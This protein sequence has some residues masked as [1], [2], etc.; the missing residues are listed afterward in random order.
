MMK[1]KIINYD[2]LKDILVVDKHK[3]ILEKF[4]TI[5]KFKN[6][7]YINKLNNIDNNKT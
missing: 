1:N 4:R 5:N 2:R 3:K 6:K 7:K